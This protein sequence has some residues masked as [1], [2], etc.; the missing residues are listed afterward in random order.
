M[1]KTVI[2]DTDG[3]VIRRQMYFSQ[4]FSN[5]FRVPAE[6]ITPFFKNEFRLC[7]A[8]KADLK[9]EL[10]KYLEQWNWYKSLD[11]L[12][13][14]W[15]EHERDIDEKIIESVKTLRNKGIHCYLDTNNE[16]Y[17]VRYI[18]ENLG[19]GNFF[20][21]V[22]SSAELGYLKAEQEFWATIYKKLGK[23]DKTEVLVWDDDEKEVAAARDFGFQA[24]LYTGFD[25]YEKRLEL[26]IK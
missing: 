2:F 19:L 17:R 24:E 13:T 22:F 12:L 20:D 3:M 21:G 1:I 4:R 26:L 5:E 18:L 23:P 8:G 11:N 25:N 6:K 14:Y 16:K 15:F 9:E 10:V 7:L